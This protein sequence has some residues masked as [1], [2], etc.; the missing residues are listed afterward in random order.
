MEICSKIAFLLARS[1]S[2]CDKLFNKIFKPFYLC[3]WRHSTD[4][5]LFVGERSETVGE[6]RI[7]SFEGWRIIFN[8]MISTDRS[9]GVGGEAKAQADER[10]Y[11]QDIWKQEAPIYFPSSRLDVSFNQHFSGSF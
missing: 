3:V 6:L 2:A 8:K 4:F 10:N 9:L 5:R 7:K 1:H 11:S